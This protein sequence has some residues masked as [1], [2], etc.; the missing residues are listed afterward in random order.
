MSE[1]GGGD[2]LAQF[3]GTAQAA[4]RLE[5]LLHEH[6]HCVLLLDELEKA[7]QP[8][9]DVLLQLLDEGQCTSGQG[10]TINARNTI[11]IATSNAGSQLILDTVVARRNLA[12]L[13]DEIIAHVIRSGVFRPELVNRFGQVVIFDPL[14]QTDL[15]LIA[16]KLLQEQTAKVEERGYELVVE[17]AVYDVFVAAGYKPG[18]GARPLRSLIGDTIENIVADAVIA[19]RPIG[20]QIVV[21][22]PEARQRVKHR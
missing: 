9:L 11:I 16:K 7:S 20:S 15:R 6:P 5:Q 3:L 18:F 12:A 14:Q 22:E 8:V 17:S 13:D 21:T 19:G 2:G 1:F 4:G 10:Q